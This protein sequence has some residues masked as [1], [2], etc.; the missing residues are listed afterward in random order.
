[1]LIIDGMGGESG[2]EL[3]PEQKSVGDFD[4]FITSSCRLIPQIPP[5]E[6][7]KTGAASRSQ[8]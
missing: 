6:S 5:W 7:Q 8:R 4:T 2:R 3:R 1:M